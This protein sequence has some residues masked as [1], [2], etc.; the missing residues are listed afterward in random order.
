[1]SNP[2]N[3]PYPVL[4]RKG[5]GAPTT[6]PL[7]TVLNFS[8]GKQ[9]SVLL[10]QVLKGEIETPPNLLV[11]SADP[12]MENS[13]SILYRDMMFAE[14][15]KAGIEAHLVPGPNLYE[16][17]IGLPSSSSTRMDN[18]PYWVQKPDGGLG[19]LRQ[20]C[21]QYYKIAPLD[22]FIRHILEERCGISRQSKSMGEAIVEKW[23]GFS[24]DE[25]ARCKN[26]GQRYVSFRY[27]LIEQGLTAQDCITWLSERGLPVPPRSVCNA[28]FANGLDTFKEMY[29][30]RPADWKQAVAVDEAVR[31][32][33][34]IGVECPVYVSKTL[35]PLADLPDAYFNHEEPVPD[36]DQWSC[37]SGHCFV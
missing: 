37:D 1:M 33:S 29:H 23:I 12:G 19:R 10:W 13:N 21:T 24:S 16:D 25:Q 9:S 2:E 28:C 31:N 30:N 32:M 8:A 6:P 15:Q 36:Q 22:R 4:M 27:P 34:K 35:E 18:P 11:L 7:L 5:W 14:C 3:A 17:L 26:P 20:G